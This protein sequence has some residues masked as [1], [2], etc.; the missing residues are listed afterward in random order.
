MPEAFSTEAIDQL[1]KR[2]KEPSWLTDLRCAA[3]A[4]HRELPWPHPSDDIWRRTDVSLLDPSKGFVPAAPTLQPSVSL[5]DARL[6]ALTK[7]LGD[8]ALAVRVNGSWLHE[9]RVPGL[10]I[11]DFSQALKRQADPLR[12]VLEADGMTPAEQKLST[13]NI[14]FHHDDVLIQVPKDC[15]LY[16]SPS[17]R[18]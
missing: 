16:T 8:E 3:W 9:P 10:T 7:P 11:E 2:L 13:L 15:L 4:K 18:D 6:A 5:T 12:Q 17:P 14:A 1:S